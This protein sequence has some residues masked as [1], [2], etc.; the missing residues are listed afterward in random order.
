MTNL[1]KLTISEAAPRIE[2]GELSSAELT[3]AFLVRIERLNPVLNAYVRVTPERARADAARADTEIAHGHYRGPLHGIPIA[4]KDIYDTAGIETNCGSHLLSGRVPER[5]AHSVARLRDAGAVLLGKLTT[6]EFAFGGP[7]WDLPS[8]P[9][10][11]PWDIKRFTGGSSSGSGAATAAGLAMATMG[12]DTGGSIRS[13]AFLCGTSGIKPTYGRVSRRG[14]APLSNTLDHIGPL[15]WTA[16]DGALVL[17]A[18]AGW[19]SVDI[20]SAAVPVPD[21]SCRLDDDLS[22]LRIGLIRHFYE[23]DEHAEPVVLSAMNNAIERFTELGAHVEECEL[24]PLTDFNACNFVIMLTEALA[25]H[26]KDLRVSPELYGACFRDRMMLGS[27]LS[28]VDYV[29]S[30]RL[31]LKLAREVESKFERFD[32]LLTAGGW[33]PAPV[34]DEMPLHYVFER[35]LLTTPFNASGHPVVSVCNGFSPEGLPVG[36]QVIGRA[37]DEATALRVA[38]AF[39]TATPYRANR[40][41]D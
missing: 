2:A 19:D 30:L 6:H 31:R 33:G 4:L 11:N 36:M 27:L 9:A 26:E 24:S 29:Q 40:P 15:T 12:S 25:I 23:R 18:L 10:R 3:E 7:S 38:S 14:V 16:R 8:P 28:G 39:E 20:G 5:D 21:F 37:Y 32:V 13:P 1:C 34:L 41:L 17:Q 22:G 35:P